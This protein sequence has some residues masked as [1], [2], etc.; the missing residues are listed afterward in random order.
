MGDMTVRGPS[1]EK[2]K[3]YGKYVSDFSV[4][5]INSQIKT[6]APKYSTGQAQDFISI[7]GT[8]NKALAGRNNPGGES[9][10]IVPYGVNNQKEALDG[11]ISLAFWTYPSAQTTV[12]LFKN[13][14]TLLPGILPLLSNNVQPGN[15]GFKVVLSRPLD[16]DFNPQT[17][18]NLLNKPGMVMEGREEEFEEL[19][20]KLIS[21]SRSS[22]NVVNVYTFP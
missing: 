17:I 11:D 4:E 15:S 7:Q 12:E 20:K 9:G 1:K 5:G 21:R 14:L 13:A 3:E 8:Y 18:P 2:R 10:E 19:R 22:N 16:Q 6:T